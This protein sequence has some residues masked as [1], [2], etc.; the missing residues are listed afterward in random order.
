M[1]SL[2]RAVWSL[3]ET[4]VQVDKHSVGP[5]THSES[6]RQPIAGVHARIFGEAPGLFN[7]QRIHRGI[8]GTKGG[9]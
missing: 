6:S 7:H 1:C 2:G 9:I 4:I 3:R 8:S 5:G